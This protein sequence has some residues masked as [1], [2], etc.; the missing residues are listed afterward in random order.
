MKN[1]EIWDQVK[2]TDLKWTKESSGGAGLTSINGMYCTMRATELFGP[3]GLGWGYEVLEERIDDG[4]QQ[5]HQSGDYVTKTH[6]IKIKLWYKVGE[7]RGEIVHFGH[8]PY[9]MRSKHGA[10][11]DDEA[12]KKSLTDA[13]KKCLSMIGV[14]ADIHL[15]QFDDQSYKADLVLEAKQDRENKQKEKEDE[16]REAIS[17]LMQDSAIIYVNSKNLSTLNK[18]HK[19]SMVQIRQ[20]YEKAKANP[21]KSINN[22]ISM[23]EEAK[24]KLETKESKKCQQK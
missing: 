1:M 17:S 3:C 16:L 21:E 8:T 6:T 15:G 5:K 19:D 22:L 13:I 14:G 12:P 2:K 23:Y 18:V 7:D 11:Q 9:I 24:K 10:Y 20:L 4:V